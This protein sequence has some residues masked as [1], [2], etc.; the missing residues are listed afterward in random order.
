MAS[1]PMGSPTEERL[2]TQETMFD[3]RPEFSGQ[4]FQ[5]TAYEDPAEFSF[6]AAEEFTAVTADSESE[7]KAVDPVEAEASATLSS[8]NAAETALEPKL[9]PF[10]PELHATHPEPPVIV[11]DA[12]P[13]TVLTVDDF[14]ALEERVLKAV[15]LVRREREARAAAEERAKVAEELVAAAEAKL[16]AQSQTQAPAIEKL[17]QEVESLRAEREQVRQR[18]ERLLSQLDALEL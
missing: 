4:E 2:E 17:E 3:E 15:G 7:T 18:V 14:A 10:Q 9:T 8:E 16:E 12:E 1:L 13:M 5:E 6:E 11:N